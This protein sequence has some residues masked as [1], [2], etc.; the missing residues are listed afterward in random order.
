M[1]NQVSAA[2]LGNTKWR[3]WIDKQDLGLNNNK[4]KNKESHGI[5]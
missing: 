1:Y 4:R 2:D 5:K 3:K